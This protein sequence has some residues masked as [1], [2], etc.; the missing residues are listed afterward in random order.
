M[1]TATGRDH[2]RTWPDAGQRRRTTMTKDE[3]VNNWLWDL[4]EAGN[5]TLCEAL[6]NEMSDLML[7]WHAQGKTFDEMLLCLK[8][9]FPRESGEHIGPALEKANVKAFDVSDRLPQ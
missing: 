8:D 5:K 1:M 2:N 3:F 6:I 4:I 7:E 9:R